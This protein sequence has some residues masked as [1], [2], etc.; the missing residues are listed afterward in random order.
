MNVSNSHLAKKSHPVF[1]KSLE[2]FR[3]DFKL[4]FILKKKK[5]NSGSNTHLFLKFNLIAV[6]KVLNFEIN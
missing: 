3:N 6:I 4:A 1:I 5:K 2:S